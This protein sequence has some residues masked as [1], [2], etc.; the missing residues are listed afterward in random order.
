M[1]IFKKKIEE[2][3]ARLM[4]A[5]LKAMEE[6]NAEWKAALPNSELELANITNKYLI[7]HPQPTAKPAPL[8]L[9][10]HQLL[11]CHR[12]KKK[13]YKCASKEARHAAPYYDS[14]DFSY[15]CPKCRAKLLRSEFELL[16]KKCWAKCCAY[17]DIDTE[18]MRTEYK[19]SRNII[20]L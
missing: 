7:R 10:I 12:S 3:Q 17:G 15:L 6:E 14:G 1:L 16:C 19:V 4:A 18:L 20:Y 2:A 11:A 9:P 5:K 13:T 8:K